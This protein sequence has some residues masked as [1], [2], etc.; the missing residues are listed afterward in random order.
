MN[1]FLIIIV[2]LL[3]YPDSKAQNLELGGEFGY[4]F[5]I[6]ND[7]FIVPDLSGNHPGNNYYLSFIFSLKPNIHSLSFNTGL[8]YQYKGNR[9][10]GLNY[11]KIP[12]GVNAEPG[13]KLKFLIGIGVYTSYLFMFSGFPDSDL[14]RSHSDFQFGLYIGSGLKYN[15]NKLWS[16]FFQLQIDFDVT[17]LYKES[18]PSHFGY[19]R[20]QNIHG[21]DYTINFGFKYLIQQKQKKTEDN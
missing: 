17:P 5:A 21:Y 8:K 1:R 15:I 3:V 4:G 13:R 20:Y 6:L 19:T 2:L 16:T 11:F 14:K 9:Y 10:F 7:H 18:I 12:F